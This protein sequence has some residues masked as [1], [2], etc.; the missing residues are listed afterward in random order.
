MEHQSSSPAEPYLIRPASRADL[1]AIVAMR[2]ALN[3]L[4]L[5]G[6]P[7]APIQKLSLDEFAALWG[8]SFADPSHAWRIVEWAG[9]PVGFGL[10][11]LLPKTR[12]LGAFIHWAYLDPAQRRAGLGKKLFDHLAGWA[13]ARGAVRIELQFIDGN[14]GARQ[15]WARMGFRSYASKCV[16]YL[17]PGE[18]E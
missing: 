8:E 7:H 17:K 1:A 11:Y 10:I 15:F 6:S 9:Q 14:E 4:E 5:S 18:S 13:R 16:C 12:P 3:A 2:D